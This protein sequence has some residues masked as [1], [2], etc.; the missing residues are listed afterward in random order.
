[1]VPRV[2]TRG[3]FFLTKVIEHRGLETLHHTNHHFALLR[4]LSLGETSLSF[5]SL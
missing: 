1:M 4:L 3:P 5:L 2:E